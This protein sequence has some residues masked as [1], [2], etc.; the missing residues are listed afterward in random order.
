MIYLGSTQ[1]AN[2]QAGSSAAQ[3]QSE[4]DRLKQMESLTP[5][6]RR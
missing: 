2:Q 1:T 6:E 4:A 3:P 5:E